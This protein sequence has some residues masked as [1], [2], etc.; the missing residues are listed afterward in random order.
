V[1][2]KNADF[3][4]LTFG[5]TQHSEITNSF[6]SQLNFTE[7]VQVN[8]SKRLLKVQILATQPS[9]ITNLFQF[10]PNLTQSVQVNASKMTLKIPDLRLRT[11]F[12]P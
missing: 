11:F 1:N 6:Q 9:E 3:G 4:I 5:Y 12:G 10:Q 2:L 7:S 8:R